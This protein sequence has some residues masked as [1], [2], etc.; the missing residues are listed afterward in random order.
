MAATRRKTVA[1]AVPEAP[2]PSG[3]R[4]VLGAVPFAK[5]ALELFVVFIGVSAAFWLEEWRQ[6]RQ[7]IDDASAIY[8]AL[9]DEVRLPAKEAGP[10]M[11][12]E[13]MAKLAVWRR[14]I[15]AGERPAL[16]HYVIDGARR[17]PTGVWDAAVGSG[18]INLVGPH[19]TYCLARFYN[20]L[21]S[22]GDVWVRYDDFTVSE[23][24]PY[25][26]DPAAF[27]DARGELRPQYV[28]HVRQLERYTEAHD[29]VIR[30]AQALMPILERGEP[31]ARCPLSD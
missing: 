2:A 20:R 8:S 4:A 24:I 12:A 7:R 30:D 26:D 22:V 15:T 27:Y 19:M 14:Q 16:V 17:P 23:V 3:W 10:A 29:Q 28:A 9:A 31:G 13:I 25:L 1:K 5:L 21:K 6:D 11:N 18:T